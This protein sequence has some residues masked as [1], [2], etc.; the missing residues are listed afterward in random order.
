MAEKNQQN[1]QHTQEDVGRLRQV[2]RDKLAELQAQ[3]RD[4][5][6]IVKYDQTH[7]TQQIRDNF[8]A[9]EFVA[10]V[11]ADDLGA[12]AVLDLPVRVSHELPR[13]RKQRRRHDEH[14]AFHFFGSP[15][16]RKEPVWPSTGG[17]FVIQ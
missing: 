16:W 15:V 17:L 2:R 10:P 3:G 8:E 14:D 7:H 5:F 12:G 6:Q 9:L 13:G 11:V 4:P 1:N